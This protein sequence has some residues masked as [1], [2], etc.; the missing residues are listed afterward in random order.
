M[1]DVLAHVATAA[2]AGFSRL[3]RSGPE[4]R[5]QV[6]CLLAISG[7]LLS[8]GLGLLAVFVVNPAGKGD[9]WVM[10]AVGGAF[11][12]VGA[13]LLF[14]GVRGSRG[15]KIPR[16][17]LY[18]EQNASLRPGT[19][20]RLRLEQPGPVTIESLKLRAVCERI[21]QRRVKPDS[22]A[23]VEDC[24]LLW[25]RELLVVRNERV[26]AGGSL[27]REAT[28]SL[29]ADAVPTGPASPEGQIRWRLE[30]SAETGVLSAVHHPFAIVVRAPARGASGGPDVE[31]REGDAAQAEPASTSEAVPQPLES[32][33]KEADGVS[34]YGCLAM[35][36]GFL[37]C[38]SLFIWM[39]FSGAA[40]RARGNP[41]MAL[42]GGALFA[43]V[44]LLALVVWF[45]SRRSSR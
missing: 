38:G 1:T 7:L 28:I 14:G 45:G 30:V 33:A 20:A 13:L 24:S 4:P 21:Y 39:F 25:E 16:V 10:P 42:F 32:G 31:A 17:E 27:G 37:G 12:L 26:P 34:R 44:G 15:L 35:A 8:V 3:S 22:S 29:P 5:G 36:V 19:S 2:P 6:G 41:Y 18:I 9:M 23:T 43:A 11:A 40:F